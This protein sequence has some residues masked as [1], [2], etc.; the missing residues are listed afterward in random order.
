MPAGLG[1]PVFLLYTHGPQGGASAG[2]ENAVLQGG[3]GVSTSAASSAC[4]R[5]VLGPRPQLGVVWV[6]HPALGG[7]PLLLPPLWLSGPKWEVTVVAA[8]GCGVE[9]RVGTLAVGG[10]TGWVA[11]SQE[12]LGL[13]VI[14]LSAA[15]APVCLSASA[16]SPTSALWAPSC[17][18]GACCHELKAHDGEVRGLDF[19]SQAPPPPVCRETLGLPLPSLNQFPHCRVRVGLARRSQPRPGG[20]QSSLERQ[21]TPPVNLT[22]GQGLQPW[23]KPLSAASEELLSRTLGSV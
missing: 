14:W 4:P 9:A 23:G 5:V 8:V 16:L 3:A 11:V 6:S 19:R 12:W 10:V 15:V 21:P 1:R 20:S 22:R 2:W 13:C 7:A 18:D 17:R